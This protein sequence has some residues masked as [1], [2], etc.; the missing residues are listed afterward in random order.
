MK[1]NAFLQ[2]LL[3]VSPTPIIHYRLD[4]AAQTDTGLQ[5]EHNEDHLAFSLQ[6]GDTAVLAVVADGMGGHQGGSEASHR[7]VDDMQ[8]HAQ[9]S[10]STM[11]TPQTLCERISE[12]NA[13]LYQ[14]SRSTLGTPGMGTTLI[15][16]SIHKGMAS[17]AFVGDSR[18]YRIRNNECLQLSNDHTLIAQLLR[19]GLITDEQARKHPDR[20]VITRALGTSAQL[21]VECCRQALPIEIGDSYLL[22]SDG[23]HDLLNAADI[24][25]I[26]SGQSATQACRQLV[27]LANARGGNDNIS[28]LIVHVLPLNVATQATPLTRT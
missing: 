3:R 28:A 14:F 22:C 5:R 18:L 9:H 17:Y 25:R 1:L 15:A 6:D 12:A 8:S 19:D 23:L 21:E 10:L 13:H 4:V 2:R 27:A 20:H 16:L 7:V 11:I 26:I 24:T